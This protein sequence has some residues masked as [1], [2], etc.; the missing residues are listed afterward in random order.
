MHVEVDVKY[1]QTNF[2]GHGFSGFGDYRLY[3]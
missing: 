2:D 3:K 1:M